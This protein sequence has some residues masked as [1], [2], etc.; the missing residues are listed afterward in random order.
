MVNPLT[1]PPT[2]TATSRRRV[3][4]F[5]TGQA[6]M[7]AKAALPADCEAVAFADNDPARQGTEIEGLRVLSAEEVGWAYYDEVRIASSASPVIYRQL[8]DA[9]LPQARL[10]IDNTPDP[11]QLARWQPR[12]AERIAAFRDRHAGE[13][14]F[15]IGNGP[16][17]RRMDLTRLNGCHCFGLN[18]IHYLL[19]TVDLQLSYHVAI[20]PHVIEQS[21]DIFCTWPI[22]SFLAYAPAVRAGLEEAENCR[23]LNNTYS[24][25][26]SGD[27]THSVCEGSTVTYAALQLAYFM[28]FD[29]VYLI[30]VDHR[31][32]T[33]GSANET[34]V[35]E[36][37]DPNHFDPRYFAN[38]TWQL[39]DLEG[40][41]FAYRRA[42]D[43]YTRSKPPRQIFDATLDGALDVFPKI[44]FEEALAQCRGKR[45]T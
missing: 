3:I 27:A 44:T 30:G 18:K 5:G 4:I 13:D 29:N 33:K 2:I 6:G 41:E 1:R 32:S 42:R 40:S 28:G 26:F 43:A 31:F 45:K 9:G 20:N 11:E 12:H 10:I 16:S 36:G 35:L 25:A 39:P 7:R 24:H 17:L 15:I 21:R 22:T 34:Q 37:D 23:L 19:E 14:C 8:I 38:Q